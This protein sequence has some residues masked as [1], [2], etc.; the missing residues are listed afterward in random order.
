V[1]YEDPRFKGRLLDPAFTTREEALRL[2]SH[3]RAR[4]GHWF[5]LPLA[6]YLEDIADI[7]ADGRLADPWFARPAGDAG[8][9]A[10]GVAGEAGETGG[11]TPSVVGL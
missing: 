6:A 7:E 11:D 5:D 4:G 8:G 3:N 2:S 1:Y 9:E 10:E